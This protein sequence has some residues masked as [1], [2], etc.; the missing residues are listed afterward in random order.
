MRVKLRGMTAPPA[1]LGKILFEEEWKSERVLNVF[2]AGVFIGGGLFGTAAGLAMSG[3]V[4]P[5]AAVALGWGIASALAGFLLRRRYHRALPLATITLDLAVVAVTAYLVYPNVAAQSPLRAAHVLYGTAAM[6]MVVISTN[7][8]RFS[9]RA[10]AW[11]VL[12][13]TALYGALLFGRGALTFRF[14]LEAFLFAGVG[15]LMVYSTVR[16]RRI[17]RRVK[18]RDALARFLPGPAVDRV[19][20][21]PLALNLGGEEHEATVLFADIRGFTA[22]S[23]GLVPAQVVALL[24]EYFEQM[25][26][27]VFRWDGIL[28]KFI[29][30]G[31]CAVFV[32][33]LGSDEPARRA[34]RCALGMMDRLRRI[35]SNR[36]S[37]GEPELKIGIGIHSGRVLA[38]NVG[39]P[40]R[41]E[42]TH[43]GDA[44]NTASR[45]EG[46]CK[47]LGRPFLVSDESYRR[48]GGEGEF[49][50]VPM[51][52]RSV[53]GKADP[54]RT[55]AVTGPTVR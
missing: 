6:V 1:D 43:I 41:M 49:A 32:P 12:W 36:A 50:A 44:V 10:V 25:V 19:V 16:L 11:S 22:L 15:A 24:N 29:G 7:V 48:A 3:R 53:R 54:L 17:V 38:G 31:L 4:N 27:E 30:D 28:D 23:S 45:V 34:I 5:G 52:P 13:G 8:I 18:E 51:E 37:R 9:P 33:R 47:E 40:S 46:L 21:D 20:Q 14:I 2:R 26:D 55:W 35:N 39:T 42:Y